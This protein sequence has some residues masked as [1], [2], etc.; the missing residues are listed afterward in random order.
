[1]EA[2]SVHPMGKEKRTEMLMATFKKSIKL[3]TV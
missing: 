3:E 1:M 2:K